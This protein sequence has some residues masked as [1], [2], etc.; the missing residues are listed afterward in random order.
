MWDAALGQAGG[1]ARGECNLVKLSSEVMWRMVGRQDD[2]R[3]RGL[4]GWIRRPAV[5]AESAQTIIV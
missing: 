1:A 5:S 4:R 2:R 3:Q